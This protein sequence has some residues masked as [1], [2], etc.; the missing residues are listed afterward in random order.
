[1]EG[2][3]VRL[4]PKRLGDAT[5]DYAWSQDQELSRL[6]GST[7]TTLPFS[8]Y[9]QA[10]FLELKRPLPGRGRFAIETRE[11]RHIG[12]CMYYDLDRKGSEVEVGILIGDREYWD[13]GYGREALALLL[14]H[15]FAT[16]DVF[17]VR[18]HTLEW[19]QRAQ[20]C[21]QKCGFAP[22]GRVLRDSQAYLLMEL[23]RG[24]WEKPRAG[25][26]HTEQDRPD[27]SRGKTT[28]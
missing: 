27:G 16:V 11:G 5:Q 2:K 12:N 9:L 10:S 22:L 23:T 25:R 21:F 26:K 17:K 19:N 24:A 13:R 3:R 6:D 14:E 28:G 8:T 7:P 1:M 4:R 15:L 18:L 20:R